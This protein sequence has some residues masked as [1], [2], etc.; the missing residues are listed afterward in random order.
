[1]PRYAW[2]VVMMGLGL[3]AASSARAQA[4]RVERRG[5]AEVAA[6]SGESITLPFRVTTL[7]PAAAVIHGRAVLPPGWSATGGG[8]RE[9]A[10]GA[11]ELRLLGVRIPAGVAAGR[12][13]VRYDAGRSADS[14]AVV[15]AARRVVA[16]T[17]ADAAPMVVA[18]GEY[19]VRFR[20]VNGGNVTEHLDLRAHVDGGAA[21][22][23]HV[24]ALVLPPAS[25]R[26]VTVRGVTDP[27]ATASLRRQVT[28][29][30]ASGAG[31][32]SARTL[33]TVVPRGA[34]RARRRGL[35][36]ELRV[37]AADSLSAAGFSFRAHGALDRAGT[38]RLEADA[39]TA[40]PA[41]APFRR[42]DEYRLRLQTP[43]LSLRL[44]DDVYALSRLTEPG[45]YAFGAG[46][47]LRVG[48]V[49]A[50]GVMARDRR[51]HGR[52]GVAGGF[53][54]V[55]GRRA[56]LG[57][58]FAAADSGA[59]RWTVEAAAAPFSL[60]QVEAEAAPAANAAQPPRAVRA[61]GNA[62]VLSY[63]ALH[64]RGAA[65]YGGTG[66]PDQDFASVTLRP[67]GA[68]S[69]SASARR[70]GDF[71]LFGDT[72]ATFATARR[73][74]LAWGSR[75]ALEYRE[76][77]GGAGGRG[78]LRAARVRIGI[79]LLRRAWLHPAYE[80]G[81][82]VYP[83]GTAAAPFH[84]LALQATVSTRGG[85]SLW[86]YAQLHQGASVRGPN[87]REW[88]GALT[89]HLP[90]LRDTWVRVSAQARRADG[91]PPEALLDLSLEHG[92]GGGH[93]LTVR[94]LGNTRTSVGGR[95]RGFVEYALP[96]ALPL[97]SGDEGLV[98][99]RAFDPATGRGLSGVLMRVGDRMAVTDRR[100]I[101][102]FGGLP[103]G[104]HTLRVEPGAGP[105]RVADREM[106][107]LVTAGGG[108]RRVEIG[109][110][111]AARMAGVV[112]RVPAGA[113]AD[114]AAPMPGVDVEISGPGGVRRLRTDAD[115]R[116]EVSGLRPGA[117]RVR[118]PDRSL[119]RHHQ[120]QEE[121]TLVLAPGGE[122]R[123]VL[124]VVEK[125]RPVQM[126]QSGELRLP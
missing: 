110:A 37:R 102:G 54:R 118:T 11:A 86:A 42:E 26:I 66:S 58:V 125:E 9:L 75:L 60:L 113:P 31:A 76:T 79:P 94:G 88:S 44:G 15:V 17:P 10:P 74:S 96:V 34:G 126:I 50:G 106:P 122:S 84:L 117:W 77:G 72:V 61:W 69:L 87:G 63:E 65:S 53:A 4:A 25:E 111:L 35:P 22:R 97:P 70:G 41:G 120:L 64:L 5:P 68:L 109:L 33:V 20:V 115:G 71:R 99:V 43:G 7:L 57:A 89:A 30:A 93:R 1:M 81:E 24:P 108:A 32:S 56:R 116:F 85:A 83:P 18:G 45:R 38:V 123:T 100:G 119:P 112:V 23:A 2:R 48:S 98:T 8:A 104:E 51:G 19:A 103:A 101:A 59:A 62:R 124:H 95:P 47:S 21:P 14:V 40:D 92:L 49:A 90:V 39:R 13:V 3:C 27:R 78:D 52:G 82:V 114:S 12:Y 46:A 80:A 6:Q 91:S 36:A 55:G 105:E 29:Y 67:F 73:A 107:V 16:V 121:Q 28:L